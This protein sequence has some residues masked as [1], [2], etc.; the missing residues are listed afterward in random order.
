LTHLHKALTTRA[1][2]G[3]APNAIAIAKARRTG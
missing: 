3:A 2:E 1:A